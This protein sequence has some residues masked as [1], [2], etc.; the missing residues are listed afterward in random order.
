[1]VK[2]KRHGDRIGTLEGGKGENGKSNLELQSIHKELKDAIQAQDTLRVWRT[3][4][5]ASDKM[6]DTQH[7]SFR[8]SVY[9][10]LLQYFCRANTAESATWARTVYQDMVKHRKPTIQILNMVLNT[11]MTHEDVESAIDFIQSEASLFNVS[12]NMRTY[13]III[14]GLALSGQTDAAQRIYDEMRT[15]ALPHRPDIVTYSTL[16]S[17][18]C[19]NGLFQEAD[20][21][22]DNMSKDNIKPNMYI[23]NTAIKRFVKQKD[24]S[25][26]RKV[27]A[28]M[29]ESDQKPDLI[30]YSILIDGYANDGDEQAI[31]D[32]QA[33]MTHNN[34][35]PNAKTITSMI[36]VFARARLDSDID[37]DLEGILKGL[38]P[39]EMNDLTYGVLMNVYGKRKD[40][41]AALGLY[42][43]IA[44]KGREVNEVIVGS[45]LDGYVRANE[46]LSADRIFH[47]HFTARGIQP[48]TAWVYSI[49]ITGCCKQHNLEDALR[50]YDEMRSFN[51]EP[52]KTICS[53]M[54]QL[55][56]Y[57][58]QLENAQA[59]LRHMRD[60]KMDITVH[61]YTMLMDY[62]SNN[63]SL[64]SALRYYQEMLDDGIQP[65]VHC[66]TV[67][68]N[69]FIRVKNFAA[70]NRTYEQMIRSG[71]EPTLEALTS[72]LHSHSLQSNIAKVK[73][74]W[75]TITDMGLFPDHVSF[76]V[77]MQTYSQQNNVEMV[78]FIFKEIT[79]KQITVDSIM[80]MTMINAYS[81]LPRLNTGRI[82]EIM[83]I[84]RD[85]ELEPTPWCYI[86]LLDT[87][88]RHKM[89]DRVVKVW[90]QIQ[91]LEKPLDW[92]PTTSNL[93]H[94][95]EACRE[96]GYIDTLHSVWRMATRGSATT[97]PAS[98]VMLQPAPEV[99]TMY[100][101]ALLTHNRFGEIEK[102]LR[103]E[104]REMRMTPRTQDFELLFTGLAQYDFLKK[105]LESIRQL[106][107]ER[108]PR[109]EPLTDRI[110]LNT[111]K[112]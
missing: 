33:E 3:Y 83:D 42:R 80:L 82:D 43:H 64:K 49:L 93:L 40:M 71:V 62:M 31:A 96:R 23:L 27:L 88:G 24:Y 67:L 18:Y 56:L 97:A 25:S 52:E 73:E 13:N 112:I 4:R 55:F 78:E 15:G 51:I 35:Y 54:I 11:M 26:A 72:M 65:D 104:C 98:E 68:M 39:G 61:T 111:R 107:V 66:Y 32:I 21:M 59:M 9:Y 37:S 10:R 47:D 58:R 16:V 92:V 44:S 17:H 74:Y 60:T 105:E 22:L 70:C 85:S 5:Q 29:T 91:S 84:M 75:E 94:L 57:H 90:N 100:L 45:L 34:I 38:P 1:M 99:F 12:L 69:A 36:K 79:Q 106:V 7:H 8:M 53:R 48:T 110:I 89:P 77:L 109:I 103:E 86:M 30:T 102:L 14:N 28:L 50:Y 101:N 81:D 87:Y 108:W 2:K 95:I 6:L 19:N 46:V 41:D 63:R 20:K 76:T